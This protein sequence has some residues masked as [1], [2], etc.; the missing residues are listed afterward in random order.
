[1]ASVLQLDDSFTEVLAP[2]YLE[3]FPVKRR[4]DVGTTARHGQSKDDEDGV[5]ERL[6][7]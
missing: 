4:M 1:M 5:G 3:G 6:I 2:T 7:H